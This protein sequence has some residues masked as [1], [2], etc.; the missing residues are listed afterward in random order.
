[1][2]HTFLFV[3]KYVNSGKNQCCF[4]VADK[5]LILSFPGLDSVVGQEVKDND[6]SPSFRPSY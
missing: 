1:M 6:E 4:Y 5:S 3:K 2:I